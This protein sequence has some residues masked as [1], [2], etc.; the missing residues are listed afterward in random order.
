MSFEDTV[1]HVLN[2]GPMPKA[3]ESTPRK[4]RKRTVK[5]DDASDRALLMDALKGH[6]GPPL[7]AVGLK[8]LTHVPKSLTS[9]LLG[10]ADGVTITKG[11]TGPLFSWTGKRDTPAQ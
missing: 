7:T 1:R 8:R 3:A 2:A 10:G 11:R 5:R 4:P 6:D 9:R